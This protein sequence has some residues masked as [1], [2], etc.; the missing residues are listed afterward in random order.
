VKL[1]DLMGAA[2]P[3]TMEYNG[4]S[5]GMMVSTSVLTPAFITTTT[6][7]NAIKDRMERGMRLSQLTAS[8]VSQMVRSWELTN[9]DGTTYPLD[10]A[11]ISQLP[12]EFLNAVV[13]AVQ[14]SLGES[15]APESG[16]TS[17]ATS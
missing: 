4:N 3:L 13:A 5:I 11:S 7:A 10:E 1:S 8:M 6:E 16:A 14:G 12:L 2:K 9:D 17:D 15:P